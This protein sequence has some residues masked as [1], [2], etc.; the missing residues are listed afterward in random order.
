MNLSIK[1]CYLTSIKLTD[2]PCS[3]LSLKRALRQSFFGDIAPC[4]IFLVMLL[5]V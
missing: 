4:I 3:A 5:P 1:D 2:T